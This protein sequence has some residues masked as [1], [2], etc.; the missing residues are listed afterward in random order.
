MLAESLVASLGAHDNPAALRDV[1]ILTPNRR[2]G[3]ELA[4]ALF[5]RLGRA[6]VAPSIRPLGDA[7]DDDDAALA[8]GPDDLSL[9]RP[10]PPARRRGAL[11]K[12][13]QRWRIAREEDELPPASALAAAD[14][15][16]ALLDQAA[17]AGGVD[18]SYLSDIA[19]EVGPNLAGHWQA[20][21]EFL[22]IVVKNWP[23]HLEENDAADPQQRRL[24]AAQALAARWA[25]QPP[26]HPVLIAGSTGAGA[27]SRTLMRAVL[28]LP[29]GRVILPGF[30]HDL[31]SSA[32]ELVAAAPSHPQFTL[33]ETV[34]TLGRTPADVALWP[35]LNEQP[36]QR[37]RRRLLNA[38]LAPAKA[39]RGWNERLRQLASPED[40]H[41]LVTQGLQ[42]LT[43]IEAEDEA[44]EALAAALLLREA[45]A[46]PG[47][48]AALVT[49][50]AALGRRVSALLERWDIDIA[51][52]GGAALTR[53]PS[54]S[55][56]LLLARWMRDPAEPVALLALLKHPLMRLGRAA[57][58]LQAA[59][60]RLELRALRG[61]RR[62]ATLERIAA[63]L[64]TPRRGRN[65]EIVLPSRTDSEAASLLRQLDELH[66]Q[67]AAPFIGPSASIAEA[68]EALA[69]LAERL[70]SDDRG[71]FA[72]LWSGRAGAAAVAFLEQLAELGAELGPIDA[73]DF[74]ELAEAAASR[75]TA[76]PDAP[77]HPRIAIWGPLEARLQRRDRIILASLNEG[78][79]PR[80]APVDAFLNRTLRRKM[81]LPDPDERIGLSAHDF[82]QLA[83]APETILLRA[84][85]VADKPAVASRWLWRLET[86]SA[87]GL[88]TDDL[89]AGD[90]GGTE[91]A[92]AALSPP[93]GNNPLD[94]ARALRRS[95]TLTPARPPE[96]RPPVAARALHEFSPS[97]VENLIRDPY[98]DYARRILLL[99][100]ERR[101]GEDID[102][103]ERGTAV[104]N[105]IEAHATKGGDL[106]ALIVAELEQS[107]ASPDM[108]AL[109]APLWRRAADAFI[110][111]SNARKDRVAD[112]T[113][114]SKGA[115]TFDAPAGPVKLEARADRIELL[116]DGTL[117]VI[118]FKTGLPPSPKQVRSGL[119]PQLALE[120]AIAARAS[121]GKIGPAPT[122][123]LIY[124]RFGL[125]RASADEKNGLPLDFD[126]KDA[127][128]ITTDQVA[129]DSLAGFL[130]LLAQFSDPDQP[131]LSRPRVFNVAERTDYD[132]LARRA[133]WSI[134]EGEE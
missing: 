3:R 2:A 39:T 76:P 111:W 74:A 125:S 126:I 72:P 53:L 1:L 29:Q 22:D 57:D 119:S 66:R 115:I 90:P 26:Q 71:D 117:A 103:R 81:G 41:A 88:S 70:A 102:A 82:A 31:D 85:R 18:W 130:R 129:E 24:L 11:A 43:L 46:H 52:S 9:P 37:A 17:I 51:P 98:A 86:L 118:D 78:S 10:Y 116:T 89:N 79:W 45:L 13:I 127:P 5:N 16:A 60:A 75:A 112:F 68:A 47:M 67:S 12:L 4:L 87:G 30:D 110:E 15:L 106:L 69:R 28:N 97:R 20:S 7:A 62:H 34:T 61:A 55:L 23:Y 25:K 113:L 40:S 6:F 54:A 65:D 80:P 58:A 123:E 42:G 95:A 14:E 73:D 93:P 114:E 108:I 77:E 38:A 84:K 48:I 104:H 124:F 64:E 27:A 21:S 63:F 128:P 109:E 100:V 133:E 99:S 96:P 91:S 44:E 121:F 35:G 101:V 120:A 131:Y 8:F 134:E 132:R 105:A 56:L 50:E 92:Q 59:I 33:L 36:P 122:S 94:W 83:N 32:W 49:P 107:G 19:E